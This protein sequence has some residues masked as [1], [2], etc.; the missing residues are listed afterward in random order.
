M[1][2][3]K[4]PHCG[5][6]ISAPMSFCPSCG[7]GLSSQDAPVCPVCGAPHAPDATECAVCGCRFEPRADSGVPSS[8]AGAT[9][10]SPA[11]APK[12]RK[13]FAIAAAVV[14]VLAV[15][16]GVI[17]LVTGGKSGHDA[18]LA[19]T[20]AADSVE[21]VAE[22]ETPAEELTVGT[23]VKR[24]KH[25]ESFLEIQYPVSGN[26]VLVQNIREWMNEQLGGSYERSL[27]DA[28]A[29]I[30]HYGKGLDTLDTGYGEYAQDKIY[31][32]YENDRIVTF[33]HY[34]SFYGGGVH[35]ISA[36][37]GVTFRK[38][39]GK[40][41]T[42]DLIREYYKLRPA[43]VRELR[44][45]FNVSSD[46]E[47]MGNLQLGDPSY[48]YTIDDIPVPKSNP[49]IT[50]EGIVFLYAPY[51]IACY[52]AGS[53]TFTLPVSEVEPYVTATAKSFFR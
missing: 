52:A 39:D 37:I 31:K 44:N 30:R 47:L 24:Y 7:G 6:A 26:P 28:D 11:A 43:I 20:L 40:I 5:A 22:E 53:P 50:A 41:F 45:Y 46:E 8:D 51:E 13:G 3:K 9:A 42:N 32:E 23:V 1:S 12:R 33:L 19:D 14:A 49:W 38:S 25:G 21:S 4:C 10:P 17:V 34:S 35:G 18:T 29:F 48:T 2:E 27:D 16:G 15:V 36:T